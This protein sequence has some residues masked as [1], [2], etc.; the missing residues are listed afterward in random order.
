[1]GKRNKKT[2]TLVVRYKFR[3]DPDIDGSNRSVGNN[4]AA[5]ITKCKA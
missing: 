5:D 3:R 1:M 4:T 2:L